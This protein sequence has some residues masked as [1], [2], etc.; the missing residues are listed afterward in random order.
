MCKLSVLIDAIEETLRV[1]PED[2]A[3]NPDGDSVL[4]GGRAIPLLPLSSALRPAVPPRKKAAAASAVVIRS[5]AELIALGVDR[6]IETSTVVLRPSPS[7]PDS[8]R[9]WECHWTQTGI[10]R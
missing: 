9:L 3:H 6:L 1:R 8:M 7:S 10:R 5:G 2:I 4:Y